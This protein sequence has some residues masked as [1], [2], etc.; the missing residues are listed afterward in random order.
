LI[1]GYPAFRESPQKPPPNSMPQYIRAFIPGGTFFFTVAILERR[2]SLLTQHIAEL[3]NAFTA[4]RAKK[5]YTMN[6]VV[7]LPDHLHCLWTLPAGD[8]DFSTRWQAI[9]SHFARAIPASENLSPRRQKKGERGIWQRRFWEHAIRD[10]NDFERHADYIHYNPVKHGHA[11]SA[12]MW[13]HSS[14][15]KFVARGLYPADW[16]GNAQAHELDLE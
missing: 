8:A 12:A 15:N 5:P 7:I 10:E 16:G 9:K 4:V 11:R 1:R 2:R 3:R 14:F 6:A 13:P